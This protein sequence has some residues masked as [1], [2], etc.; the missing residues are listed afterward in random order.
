MAE[1]GGAVTISHYLI[2]GEIEAH[3]DR[4][5]A[6]GATIVKQLAA[7]DYCARDYVVRDPEGHLWSSER[8]ASRR[9]QARRLRAQHKEVPMTDEDF[10]SIALGLPRTEA[11]QH[12]GH[13]DFRVR[14]KVFATLGYPDA[15]WGMVKLAP[16][17]QLALITA[18]PEVF[19]AVKGA[20]GRRGAASVRLALADKRT[21]RKAIASA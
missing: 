20:W 4:A 9:Y 8:T 5:Q 19:V 16:D 17:E 1:V 13:P 11:S 6:A 18:S 10:R 2:V 15:G 21:M 12:T 3:F 7:S 14:G